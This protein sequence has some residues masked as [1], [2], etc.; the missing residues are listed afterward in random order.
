MGKYKI[1]N[2]LV[3]T[4][5]VEKNNIGR[6]GTVQKIEGNYYQLSCLPNYLYKDDCLDYASGVD[7]IREERRRQIEQDGYDAL[8]DR[9]HTPQMLCRA[10]IGYALHEDRSKLVS[11]AAANL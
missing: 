8:H 4:K 7:Q 9:H 10:A 6:V 2:I 5:S 1:G 3:I 11:D